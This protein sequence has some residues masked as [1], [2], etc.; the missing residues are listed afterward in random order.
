MKL[1]VASLLCLFLIT[2]SIAD[3]R[4]KNYEVRSPDGNITVK[5]ENGD[6]LLWSVK[7]KGQQIMEPSAI[8]L[9][10]GNDE[11]L[12]DHAIIR[13]SKISEVDTEFEAINYRKSVIKDRYNELII[14]CKN[15]FGVIFRAYND[16]VAYRFFTEKRGEILVY[17][18]EANF[19][20]SD[21]YNVFAP[22][23]WDYRNGQKFNASFESLYTRQRISEFYP[24]SLIFLP[25][26]V[27]LGNG[28]KVGILEADLENY[29]G[30]YLVIN[31]THQGYKGLYAPFPLEAEQYQRNYIPTKRAAYIARVNG[32]RKF[33]WRAIVISEQDKEL[34]DND[35]VQKLASPSRIVDASWIKPGQ[36]AW[37]W[38]NNVNVSHVDFRAGYNTETYKYYIDFAHSNHIPYIIMDEGWFDPHDLTKTRPGINLPEIIEH[39]N[40]NHVGVILW[41]GWRAL[42]LQLEPV[43]K[44]YAE[45]GIRGFKI[46]FIDRDDQVAVESTYKMAE[47]A[48][49]YKLILDFHGVYKPTGLQRTY[50]NIVGYEGVR[51]LEN[52]KWADEDMPRYEVTLPFIRGLAGP[53]DYTPGAMRNSNQANYRAIFNNP[54]SKGTRCHQMAMYVVYEAPLQMLSDNPTTYTREQECTDFITRVPVTCDE[55]VPLDGL[56]GEYVAIARKK[57]DTWFVGAMT[58]WTA[59]TITLDFSFLDEGEYRAVIFRDGTNA[60]REGTDYIKEPGKVNSRDN[61]EI[62]MASGGGWAAR[63][64]PV[65][66]P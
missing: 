60:D 46:D 27:D 39:G 61:M 22:Y 28:K 16:A 45:M 9:N 24:D 51:G 40:R 34:L 42:T 44:Q 58:N 66:S 2:A 30:M 15:D 25:F 50:P 7:H 47:L 63:L 53:V 10:L 17:N 4:A 33:P 1:K 36:V 41:V 65:K 49:E 12:G 14:N 20:F 43:F 59:R 35:I 23:L 26:L 56:V 64:E 13:K 57:G 32:S 18:E 8:A 52:Y 37:D 3:V 38:W 55:T 48:A 29:P 54:M 21:D 19:N 11:I 6:K 5:I 31:E 62:R